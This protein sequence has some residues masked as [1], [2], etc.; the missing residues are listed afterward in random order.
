MAGRLNILLAD[1]LVPGG[2]D[3]ENEKTKEE[4]RREFAVAKHKQKV[5]VDKAFAD[6]FAWLTG[7]LTYL[8]AESG[9]R[10][11][12]VRTFEKAKQLINKPRD[13]DLDVAIVDLSWW[14]DVTLDQGAE[15]RENRGLELLEATPDYRPKVPII[16]LSQNFTKHF[17]LFTK[18]V[19]LGAF[20]VPKHRKRKLAYSALH[21]A[22]RY[23]T[24]ERRRSQVEV[25]ICH[26]HEDAELARR[27]VR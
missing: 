26:A 10:V 21:A 13:Q 27:L 8:E 11:I 15:C 25:F 16:A 19:E 9:E 5:N 23:L 7:L 18:V 17:G 14:G 12:R 4:I 6:D 22:A 3:D 24:R 1:D 20:P 2:T